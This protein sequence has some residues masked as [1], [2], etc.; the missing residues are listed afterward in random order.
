MCRAMDALAGWLASN[1][2]LLN[3]AKTQFIWLGDRR[4]LAGVD[5]CAV[6][7]TFPHITFHHYVR[8][9]G[10]ILDEELTFTLIAALVP[11]TIS[12]VNYGSSLAPFPR[13]L[14]KPSSMPLLTAVWTIAAPYWLV[15]LLHW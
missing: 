7:E 4:K 14:Q 8:D 13:A 6:A 3:T 2:L 5:R 1:R 11:V 12:Y 15:C 9:L 10:V